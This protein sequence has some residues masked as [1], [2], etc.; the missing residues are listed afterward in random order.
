MDVD[1]DVDVNVG[2]DENEDEDV[3]RC[4]SV[5]PSRSIDRRSARQDSRCHQQNQSLSQS[6]SSFPPF[7][8][9]A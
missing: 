5:L 3:G 7:S 9:H 1:V 8:H 6:P 2:I 4:L